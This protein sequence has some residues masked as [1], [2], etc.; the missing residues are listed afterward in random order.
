[1]SLDQPQA[2]SHTSAES[3]PDSERT[4]I[5]A[6]ELLQTLRP[7]ILAMLNGSPLN[8]GLERLDIMPP[9]RGNPER[10]HV[11]WVGPDLESDDGKRLIAVCSECSLA[12]TFIH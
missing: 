12:S 5:R 11:L 7:T 9:E 4:L 2:T 8:I 6:S 3:P 10:A 1:M